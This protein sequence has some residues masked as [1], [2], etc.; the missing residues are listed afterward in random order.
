MRVAIRSASASLLGAGGVRQQWLRSWKQ[1]KSKYD[2]LE[3]FLHK[4]HLLSTYATHAVCDLDHG[5]N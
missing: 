4:L 3:Q 5:F 2:D 1:H